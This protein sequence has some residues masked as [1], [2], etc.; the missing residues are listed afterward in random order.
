M[1]FFC[2]NAGA[3]S[4]FVNGYAGEPDSAAL[5]NMFHVAILA[6]NIE[7]WGEWVPSKANPA[8][9]RMRPDRF[10]EFYLAM[11]GVPLIEE[12]MVHWCCHRSTSATRGCASGSGPRSR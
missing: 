7:W 3:L 11:E 12:A 2:D 6:L 1:I 10:A 9:L 8:D 5:V 4:H